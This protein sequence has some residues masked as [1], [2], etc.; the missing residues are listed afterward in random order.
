MAVFRNGFTMRRRW[1]VL[2]TLLAFGLSLGIGAFLWHAV[3]ASSV[4][5]IQTRFEMMKPIFSTIRLLVIGLVAVTWPAVVQTLHRWER[6]N[7]AGAARLLSLR[8]RIVTWLLVIELLLGR[9]LL[10]QFLSLFQGASV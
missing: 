5:A 6:V 9:N 7:D 2:L 10:G 4:V 1:F 3:Q 8:W